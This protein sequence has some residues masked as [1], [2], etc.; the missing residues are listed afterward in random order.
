MIDYKKIVDAIPQADYDAAVVEMSVTSSSIGKNKKI[1][2]VTGKFRTLATVETAF[3]S[4]KNNSS[5]VS[6]GD[7]F[8]QTYAGLSRNIGFTK[9][10]Q[11]E[12]GM[13]SAIAAGVLSQW[14]DDALR[15]DGI[16]IND[17]ELKAKFATI[18]DDHGFNGAL[19]TAITDSGKQTILDFPNLK[20]GHVQNALQK[21]HAGVI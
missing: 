1:V 7:V 12:D 5:I 3:D 6:K 21:R 17:A 9:T 15:A 19:F 10:A 8:L 4:I 11:F 13:K 20:M 14:L 16:N 2:T 18:K